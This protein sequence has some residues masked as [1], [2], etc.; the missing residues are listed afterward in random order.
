MV[1][2]SDLRNYKRTV[3]NRLI[4]DGIEQIDLLSDGTYR[5]VV[6]KEA[7]TIYDLREK[8]DEVKYGKE[9]RQ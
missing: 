1:V 7:E 8:P 9:S 5:T 4:A 6:W 2:E 3:S